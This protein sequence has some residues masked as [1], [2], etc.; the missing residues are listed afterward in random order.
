MIG[1]LL[2]MLAFRAAAIG[3]AHPSHTFAQG[4]K[5]LL[6]GPP[7]TAFNRPPVL[8]SRPPPPSI[9][10]PGGSINEVFRVQE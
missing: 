2:S 8:I 5:Q 4:R 9:A 7:E 6:T 1:A 3:F 10:D